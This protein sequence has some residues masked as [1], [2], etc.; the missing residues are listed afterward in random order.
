MLLGWREPARCESARCAP[1]LES[2]KASQR[3]T[4][5]HEAHAENSAVH[6]H[7]TPLIGCIAWAFQAAVCGA[8]LGGCLDVPILKEPSMGRQGVLASWTI[9]L[10]IIAFAQ[11]RPSKVAVLIV[12]SRTRRRRLR[13]ARAAGRF[14]FGTGI[15]QRTL[16]RVSVVRSVM[17]ATRRHSN[18]WWRIAG[19]CIGRIRQARPIA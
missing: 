12:T 13:S 11:L 3:P 18:R 10:A 2:P 5:W 1:G 17:V 7:K 16:G 15:C 14:T 8:A 4:R 9:V 19:S 6:R